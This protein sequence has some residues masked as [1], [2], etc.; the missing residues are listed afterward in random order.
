MTCAANSGSCLG[1]APTVICSCAGSN[2]HENAFTEGV[3]WSTSRATRDS[4]IRRISAGLSKHLKV[5]QRAGLIARGQ[6]AQWRPCRLEAGPLKDVADWVGHYRRFWTAS[7][8]RLDDYLREVQRKEKRHAGKRGRRTPRT[9]E[10]R[11]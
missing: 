1:R 7:F 4:P 2:S 9:R 6:R 10:D 3:R 5:L 8:D 11:A